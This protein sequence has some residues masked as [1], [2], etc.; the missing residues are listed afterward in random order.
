MRGRDIRDQTSRKTGGEIA[1]P[2]LREI[3]AEAAGFLKVGILALDAIRR[4]RAAAPTTP[5]VVVI[6]E[7]G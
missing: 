2:W 6:R 7:S 3:A 4:S 1:G 5:S